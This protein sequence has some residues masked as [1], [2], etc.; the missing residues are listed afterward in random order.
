MMQMI[1][2]TI[3][4]PAYQ[5][6][7]LTA[8]EYTFRVVAKNIA[9]E[10][11]DSQ[12]ATK[13]VVIVPAA[14]NNVPTFGDATIAN[15]TATVGKA[16]DGRILP[17][18][19]DA[20]SGDTLT[21]SIE[22]DL[23]DGLEFDDDSRALTGTP[24]E[25]MEQTTY[26]YKVE[27]GNDG[28]DT[29]GFLIT[30]NAALDPTNAAPTFADDAK[31]NN[32]VATV[33]VAIDGRILPEATDADSDDTLTYS[34]T[35]DLP[36]G[37][38]FDADTR[39][40]TGT[41]T[42]IQ[43]QTLYTY[44]VEDGNDGEDSISFFITVNALPP[45]KNTAPAFAAD[46]KIDNIVATVGQAIDGRFL[47]EATDA[48]SDDTLTYSLTPD[49][50][51]GLDF[52]ADTRALT[53]TPIA[54]QV[55]TPYTYKVMDR[56]AD[57]SDVKSDSISF[58]ITVK[59][60]T[61]GPGTGTQVTVLP[62]N[63]YVVYVRSLANAPVF[64]TANP[65]VA[66]WANMPDLHA[67]FTEGG[68]GSLQLNVTGVNAR[69]VVFSEVMWA[70]D[71]GKVGQ[72]SYTGQQWIELRNRTANAI[73]ISDI[74]FETQ[75]GRPALPQGTDLISN[76]V[77]AGKDWIKTGKGQSGNSTAGSLKEFISMYRK[78][79]HNDSA[80]WNDGEWVQSTLVYHPNH[81]GTPGKGE[82]SGP[83]VIG[84]SGVAL[85]TVINEVANHPSGSS[86]HEWI[87]LR[88]KS[89]ELNNLENWVVDMVTGVD[90]QTRL[91]KIPKLNDGRYGDI[92]LITKTDP[93]RDDS[94][95]LRGGYDVTKDIG[96]Q[97]F[98]GRDTNIRYYVAKDWTTDL[99]A[100]GE[101][102]LILRH[103][104]DKTNH[105]K[106]EDIAGYHPNLKV[107]SATFFTNLWPPE[108]LSCSSF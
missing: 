35:P 75:S 45:A 48:D 36:A 39:A 74:S 67:L 107:D 55:Q 53:G 43:A 103:G 56:A 47:P 22:P 28:E 104:A 38:D 83:K 84:P 51:A 40:L 7:G 77:G 24:T 6:S 97:E 69:Q 23:P 96:A 41:P 100:N 102:V 105:E 98:E 94:H 93:A 108:W 89:G 49:L 33:N 5:V 46:A 64:G 11:P 9:G 29:I 20:D 19:T 16:I 57:A 52:D 81:K 30:V 37:L 15:I 13:R 42:E 78:R 99:P 86:N 26:T 88:K 92:L 4:I 10:S 1:H 95:P 60:A 21:Y 3:R 68:G 44:K 14:P 61:A 73:N 12:T 91:F 8:G 66:E 71:E 18:A 85:G 59:A 58:F 79:Y 87:E 82:P 90:A 101:F 32:I 76:V 17:E 54:E 65:A 2:S 70:V 62:A 80:G 25:A 27:D 31:I 72:E 63:G 50:P 106:V 34:L